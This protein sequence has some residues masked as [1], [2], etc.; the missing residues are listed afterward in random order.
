M[1]D[2]DDLI[3]FSNK[4]VYIALLTNAITGFIGIN[5]YDNIRIMR[6]S[7][8]KCIKYFI[9]LGLLFFTDL[10][11]YIISIRKCPHEFISYFFS[12]YLPLPAF[13]GIIVLLIRG[14]V[15]VLKT[16]KWKIETICEYLPYMFLAIGLK[17]CFAFAY[18]SLCAVFWILLDFIMTL[19][20]MFS[21]TE[22]LELSYNS[23]KQ[24]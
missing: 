1:I 12:I 13:F 6:L 18:G 8:P 15:S 24:D 4:W 2:I 11:I 21:L 7:E 14:A 19:I 9:L 23:K 3:S 16:H 20:K 10:L 22:S 17:I 5:I